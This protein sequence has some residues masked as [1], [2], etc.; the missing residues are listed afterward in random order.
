MA[1]RII[2]RIRFRLDD[3]SGSEDT[4]REAAHER[5]PEQTPCGDERRL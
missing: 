3:A 4:V 2:R 5:L 1:G